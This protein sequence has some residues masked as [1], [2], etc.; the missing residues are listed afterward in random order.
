MM[1]KHFKLFISSTF[2]DMDV[3]RDIIKFEVIPALNQM[4]N[5]K[6]VDIQAIDLRYGV[7]TSG[8]SEEEASD[9]VLNT[10][11]QSIDRAR[12][13]FI[14][15]LG[16][17]Y[18]SIPKPERWL[19]FYKQLDDNQKN[20]MKNSSGMS[21]TEMEILYSGAFSD[22]YKDCHF[23]FFMRD[24]INIEEIPEKYRIYYEEDV[25]EIQSKNKIDK[26]KAKIK[27]RCD[28]VSNSKCFP[29]KL[30]TDKDNNLCAPCLA[31]K[32][33]D[34][35]ANMINAE[36]KDTMA[37]SAKQPAWLIEDEE[38]RKRIIKLYEGSLCRP[39]IEQSIEMMGGSSIIYG[40]PFSGKSTVL[41]RLY[42]KYYIDDYYQQEGERKILLAA[43]VNSSQYSR[44]IHQI[45]GRWVVELAMLMC[46]SQEDELK[47]ALIEAAPVNHHLIRE[48]FYA[49]VDSIREAGHSVHIFIDDLDQFLL[50]S[51][52]DETLDW[53]DDRV[54]IYAS[55]NI[56]TIEISDI[57][58]LPFAVVS[59]SNLVEDPEYAFINAIKERYFCELPDS[60]CKRIADRQYTFL[61]AFTFFKMVRLFNKNDFKE[62]R[63]GDKIEEVKVMKLFNSLPQNYEKLF[64]FFVDFFTERVGSEQ[65]YT[66][67]IQLLKD[68]PEGMRVGEI[69]DSMD[70]DISAPE[71]YNMLYYFNDFVSIEYDTEIIKF[72]NHPALFKSYYHSLIKR[73]IL[74]KIT[75]QAS[76]FLIPEAM[77][78]CCL[79]IN[80]TV[81][82]DILDTKSI[83]ARYPD[84]FNSNNITTFVINAYIY[85]LYKKNN[86]IKNANLYADT[87]LSIAET[88][89]DDMDVCRGH[90][91]WSKAVMLNNAHLY[92]EAKIAGK[93]ALDIFEK[94]NVIFEESPFLYTL[95]GHLFER[96]ASNKYALSCFSRAL[97]ILEKTK[98]RDDPIKDYLLQR[99]NQ[100]QV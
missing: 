52:G 11:V 49:L 82:T 24:E 53:V 42:M 59:I 37:I 6:G 85:I 78:N 55:A 95:V 100:L 96:E 2:K 89:G 10:C 28:N 71:I 15:F 25:N 40:L 51:P 22:K 29:Y 12:P 34:E 54:T 57:G 19:D 38:I 31:K 44:N 27:R 41:A 20:K 90:V 30:M 50:T 36:L 97:F 7:N 17:R 77:Q 9:K 83:K 46:V 56:E 14:S 70:D 33:I 80:E 92:T 79:L 16:N 99:I 91:F 61:E 18:G 5:K 88:I 64:A 39:D 75:E 58:K 26:L 68:H 8:L 72:R 23:L 47:N 13:F 45:M 4:F 76:L 73:R 94:K 74:M 65:K 43:A 63:S 86:D 60:I 35:I 3:E 62:M 66:N 84:L 1:L 87:A 98:Y 48:M 93:K 69:I 21:I 67:L 81:P 32:L